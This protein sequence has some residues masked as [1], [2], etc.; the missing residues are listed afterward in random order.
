MSASNRNADIFMAR[1]ALPA[2]ESDAWGESLTIAVEAAVGNI[3]ENTLI[4]PAGRGRFSAIDAKRLLA[5]LT[6]SYARELYSS[7]EI[8]SRLRRGQSA[9][10]WDG[11]VPEVADIGRFRRENRRTLQSCLQVVLHYLAAQKVADG[12]VTAFNESHIAAEAARRIIMSIFI[13]S[14]EGIAPMRQ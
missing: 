14:T 10:L 5:L 9:E 13:D 4:S 6:W 11:G 2:P 12:I 1:P 8:H 3:D 7:A